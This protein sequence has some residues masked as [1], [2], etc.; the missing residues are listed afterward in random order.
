MERGMILKEE[1]WVLLYDFLKG[2]GR[3]IYT[4][5]EEKTRNFIEAVWWISR[6]GAQWR[7]LPEKYVDWNTAYHRFADWSEKGIWK[8]MFEHF[9]SD[10]DLEYLMIDS[11]IVRAHACAAGAKKGEMKR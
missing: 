7:L 5:N 11:T 6:S 1:A 3:E 4:A 8:K 2:C 10:R 9:S